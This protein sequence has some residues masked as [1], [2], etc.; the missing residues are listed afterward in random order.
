MDK[1]YDKRTRMARGMPQ[2][3]NT[4]RITQKDTK[5]GIKLE[6]V[7]KLW[8]TWILVQEIHLHSRQTST[9]IEQMP[10]RCPSTWLDD[11]KKDHIDPIGPK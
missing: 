11:E 4:H 8:N 10:T 6:N 9:R 5:K 2:S 3:G 1:W 7:R